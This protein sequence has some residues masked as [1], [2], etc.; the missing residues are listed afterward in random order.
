MLLQIQTCIKLRKKWKILKNDDSITIS[1]GDDP[2]LLGNMISAFI[3]R[4]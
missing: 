3:G 1:G 2:D 4:G